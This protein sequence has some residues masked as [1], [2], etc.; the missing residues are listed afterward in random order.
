MNALPFAEQPTAVDP[1]PAQPPDGHRSPRRAW[2]SVLALGGLAVVALAGML[3]AGTLPRLRQEQ[4]VN[5]QAAAVGKSPPRVTVA[6]ASPA[7]GDA[8]R[9]LPGNALPLLD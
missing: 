9:V 4:A 5:D 6:V 3:V 1:A 2:L 8:E 7:A